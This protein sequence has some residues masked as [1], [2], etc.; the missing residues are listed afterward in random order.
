MKNRK[1]GRLLGLASAAA[2]LLALAPAPSK[3]EDAKALMMKSLG[4]SDVGPIVE[5][6]FT[7]FAKGLT[8]EQ[9]ARQGTRQAR[10]IEE[11]SE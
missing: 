2:L 3:A 1:S 10:M 8:P 11:K 5:E 7:R 4:T 6:S 9:R